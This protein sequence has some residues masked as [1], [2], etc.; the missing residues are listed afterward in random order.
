M[1]LLSAG[2]AGYRGTPLAVP[3]TP[4]CGF[5]GSWSV[6]WHSSLHLHHPLAQCGKASLLWE[7]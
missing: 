5:P 6:M 3:E 1:S 4:Q 7:L 2:S